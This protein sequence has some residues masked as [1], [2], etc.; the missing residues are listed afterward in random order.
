[1]TFENK[2]DRPLISGL[3]IGGDCCGTLFGGVWRVA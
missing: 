2:N 3:E 1:M